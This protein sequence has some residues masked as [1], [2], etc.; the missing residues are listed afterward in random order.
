M[1]LLVTTNAAVAD[2]ADMSIATVAAMIALFMIG[3]PPLSSSARDSVDGIDFQRH[4]GGRRQRLEAHLPAVVGTV[5]VIR[6]QRVDLN[7]RL[8]RNRRGVSALA[9][10]TPSDRR[11]SMSEI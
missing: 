6:S 5:E 8:K 1:F 4:E 11:V 3:P 10:T 9:S 7:G 2:A